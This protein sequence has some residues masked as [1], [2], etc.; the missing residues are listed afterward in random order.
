MT[1][2]SLN[3]IVHVHVIVEL[4]E[5]KQK[6]D[7]QKK[8]NQTAII[9]IFMGKRRKICAIGGE[10]NWGYMRASF[11]CIELEIISF[12]DLHYF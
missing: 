10:G 9:D 3:L 6:S 1:E 8:N 4:H 12:S 5:N 2:I 11:L 7:S